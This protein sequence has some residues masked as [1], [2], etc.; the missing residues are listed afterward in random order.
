MPPIR[1]ARGWL[2]IIHGVAWPHDTMRYALGAMLLDLEDPTKLIGLTRSPILEPEM[3]Y[4]REG[5]VPNVV[6]ACGAIADEGQDRIRVYYG[7]GDTNIGLASGSL[8]GLIEACQ[9]EQRSCA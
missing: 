8:S 7:G 3:P 2:V 1:T 9:Q 6:F 5:L 4:E